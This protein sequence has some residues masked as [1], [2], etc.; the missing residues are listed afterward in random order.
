M[1]DQCP[2]CNHDCRQGR[3]C[4]ARGNRPGAGLGLVLIIS[5]AL[6]SGIGLW[7]LWGLL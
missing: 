2:P 3:D 6:Y 1:T 7:L 5:A 4:P